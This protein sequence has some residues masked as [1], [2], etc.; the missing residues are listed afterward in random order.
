M[1]PKGLNFVF[2]ANS[3]R[4]PQSVFDSFTSLAK[5]ILIIP[6]IVVV[7]KTSRYSNIFL[8]PLMPHLRHSDHYYGKRYKNRSN[9]L[10]KIKRLWR[11]ILYMYFQLVI[12][13]VLLFWAQYAKIFINSCAIFTQ[14]GGQKTA[15]RGVN[16]GIT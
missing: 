7:K 15:A 11:K 6:F 8:Q 4:F 9:R 13:V 5:S 2:E 16:P 3:R 14:I 1:S 10:S 12:T